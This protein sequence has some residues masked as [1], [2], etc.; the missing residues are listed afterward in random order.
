[1]NYTCILTTL[2]GLGNRYLR[3]KD[4][5]LVYTAG[6]ASWFVAIILDSKII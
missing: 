2:I 4:A 5:L 3:W 1:M 6:H